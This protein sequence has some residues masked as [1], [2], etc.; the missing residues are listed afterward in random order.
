MGDVYFLNFIFLKKTKTIFLKMID[1][2]MMP[3]LSKINMTF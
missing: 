2:D 3:L 1:E